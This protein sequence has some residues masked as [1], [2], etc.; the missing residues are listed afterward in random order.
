M[1]LLTNTYL[2]ND[3]LIRKVRIRTQNGEYDRPIYK[4]WVIATKQEF[5]GVEQ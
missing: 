4:L 2:G 1:V 3:G 5:S